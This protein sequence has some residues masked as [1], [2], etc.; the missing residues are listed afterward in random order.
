VLEDNFEF[1]TTR[2]GTRVITKSLEDFQSKKSYFDTQ[3]L[4]YYTFPKSEK[5]INSVIRHLPLNTPAQNISD[6]LVNLGFDVVSVKQMTT[7]RRS[8]PEDPKTTNLPPFLV[9]LTRT[10]KSQEIFR[11]PSLCHIAIRVEGYR[12]QNG[13]TQC[14]NGQQ[15]GHVW[16][17]CKQPPRCLWC[18]GGHL[19]NECPEKENTASTLAC[20]NCRLA[21]G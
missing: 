2:N 10:V 12:N 4:S 18:G 11:L 9:T 19:H 7:T 8:S 6:G 1:R 5:P 20:C 21:E 16:A 3:H 14:H 17:N 15:V 13:P